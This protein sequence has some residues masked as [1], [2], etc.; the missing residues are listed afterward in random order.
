MESADIE[1]MRR[2]AEWLGDGHQVHLVTVVK[3]W[4]SSPRPVGSLLAVSDTGQPVGSVSGGCVEDDLI[5]KIISREVAT[6]AP[7]LVRYGITREEGEKFGLPCGGVLKLVVEP[8]TQREQAEALVS[9]LEKR[10]L[11]TR[12]LDIRSG[13]SQLVEQPSQ[14]FFSF[15]DNVLTRQ[16]GPAWQVIL[17]GAG[18]LSY[19][20]AQILMA[21]NYR[22]VICDPRREYADTWR[23]DGTEV[24][25]LMPDDLIRE[26]AIDEHTAI[27]TLTHDPKI[28]DL[29]LLEALCSPAFYV[30][31][32]GSSKTQTSRRKRLLELGLSP[33]QVE[34]LY[35]P[36]GLPIGSHTPMEIAVA[37]AAQMVALRNGVLDQTGTVEGLAAKAV[38]I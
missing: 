6:K 15:N 18:D 19:Y 16:F 35:G 34:R 23:L 36:A 1:I 21:L 26:R 22:L 17:I 32:L 25:T 14:S 7:E 10:R 11:I 20:V 24:S 28:D 12:T 5:K 30:A 33:D 27:I 37:I 31:A 29:A 38:A 8:F 4:G 2:V 3:T 13:V 9:A